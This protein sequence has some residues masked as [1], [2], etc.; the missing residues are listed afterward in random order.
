MKTQ[1]KA[2]SR[3]SS[4]DKTVPPDPFSTP[5]SI[6][7]WASRRLPMWGVA[8]GSCVLWFLAGFGQWEASAE[9]QRARGE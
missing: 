2:I 6:L 5:F 7:F 1:D 3:V 4:L 9:N 8:L